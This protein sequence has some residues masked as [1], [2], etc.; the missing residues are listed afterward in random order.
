MRCSATQMKHETLVRV[1]HLSSGFWLLPESN[2]PFV[3]IRPAI[4]PVATVVVVNSHLASRRFRSV[5]AVTVA[6]PS[7]VSR[8]PL[9][10]TADRQSTT[11]A[12]KTLERV[13]GSLSCELA[14]RGEREHGNG[15]STVRQS[16]LGL[17]IS[18]RASLHPRRLRRAVVVLFIA[19][20]TQRTKPIL[21]LAYA[22]GGNDA[23]CRIDCR[24]R[25]AAFQGL[26]PVGKHSPFRF[27]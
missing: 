6:A 25:H 11:D 10:A 22:C 26:A 27:R 13:S 14:N 3:S 2:W 1:R 16:P 19:G 15:N 21:R 23:C 24:C 7:P 12:P 8:D 20:S 18:A 17:T 5:S 4:P 9:P